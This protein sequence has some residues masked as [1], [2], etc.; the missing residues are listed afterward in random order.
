MSDL[1]LIIGRVENIL[2]LM[3]QRCATWDIP[4]FRAFSPTYGDLPGFPDS[5][6]REYQELTVNNSVETRDLRAL[7]SHIRH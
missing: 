5:S 2:R 6:E 4:P 1:G 3:S 7:G